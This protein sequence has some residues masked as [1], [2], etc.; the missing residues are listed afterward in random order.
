MIIGGLKC[1]SHKKEKRSLP[2]AITKTYT[3]TFLIFPMIPT[4]SKQ[5]KRV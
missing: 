3:P 1:N 5:K 4:F 2:V